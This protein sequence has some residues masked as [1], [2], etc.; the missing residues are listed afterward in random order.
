MISQST[1]VIVIGGGVMGCA[2]AYHL[3]QG[4]QRVTL[5]E[6][7]QIGHAHGSSH[8]PSRV[9]RLNYEGVDYV[10]LARAAYQQWH[11][12]EKAAAATLLVYT[13]GMDIGEP[14]ALA[15]MCAT[16]Q[17]ANVPFE[18]IDSAEIM[19]R[20][21]Q[22][23]VPE[24]MIALYQNDYGVLLADPCVANM[25]RL[26]QQ[27]GT[28]IIEGETVQHI[29][30]QREG[31][32]VQTQ[33][34][35][36]QASR[37]IIAAGSWLRPLLRPLGVDLPLTVVK[38]TVAYYKPADPTPFMPGRFPLF[39]Q[40]F[41]NSTVIGCGFPIINHAG[42]K[43]I[44][45]RHGPVVDPV[46]ED[47]SA[48]AEQFAKIRGYAQQVLPNLGT[49]IIEATTCRYTMTPDENF[50]IDR[51][52]AYPQVVIGSPCSGHGFKFGIVIGK[53]LA[54]LALDGKTAYDI[55]RFKIDR[56]ALTDG[57]EWSL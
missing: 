34:A 6:Q 44:Y 8:G 24:G 46:D 40:R 51:L 33:R 29:R 1:D 52:P 31:V 23:R 16:L 55:Q 54:E 7:F 4:G 10:Q 3:A 48:S 57:T 14:D 11:E 25:S 12:L 36:Y 26:A 50:I 49:D 19:R 32:E 20:S 28:T 13:G 18:T 39:L 22:M 43:M 21:P 41:P 27:Q 45:D 47:R 5:L 30:P 37:V 17:A 15:P 9:I 2:A 35:T 38:E 53:I 56:P 42:V